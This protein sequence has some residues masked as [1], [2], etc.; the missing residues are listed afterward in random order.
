MPGKP[1][2]VV[3]NHSSR[4]EIARRLKRSTRSQR[5]QRRTGTYLI[6]LRVEFTLQRDCYQRSGALLPHPFTLT[7]SS[8]LRTMNH[9][10]SSLCCTCRGL[11]PPRRYLAPCPVEP[12][13]SSPHITEAIMS[14]DCLGISGGDSI[15][16]FH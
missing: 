2:S 7:C 1:G 15:R 16:L 14:S 4:P 13:L 10:R 3:D 8:S 5:G 6:L 11:A 9:R 12:G